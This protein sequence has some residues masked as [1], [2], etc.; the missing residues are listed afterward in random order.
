VARPRIHTAE[1]LATYRREWRQRRA[2]KVKTARGYVPRAVR[3]RG[4]GNPRAKLDW[5]AVRQMRQLAEGGHTIRSLAA[6]FGVGYGTAWAVVKGQ[7][8]RAD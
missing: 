3:Q 8:W 5:K 4:E 1:E 6:R 2:N 7:T